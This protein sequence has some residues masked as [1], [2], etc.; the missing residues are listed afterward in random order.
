[1]SKLIDNRYRFIRHL[2]AG[3]MAQVLLVH[4][5]KL[6]RDVALKFFP[7][8]DPP[9]DKIR[10][11]KY[12]CESCQSFNHENLVKL[13]D[14][15]ML[16]EGHPYYTMEFLPFPSLEEVIKKK[17]RCSTEYTA[18]VIEQVLLAYK[19]F[20]PLGIVHRDIKPANLLIS[21]EG[22]VVVVDFG[23]AHDPNRTTLT[24]T[25]QFVGTPEYLAPEQL[26]D[27]EV[28]E[29]SDIYQLGLVAYKLLSGERA[30]EGDSLQEYL[31]NL[32]SGEYRPLKQFVPHISKDWEQYL[33]RC[34]APAM[35]DRFS[36]AD[37]ALAALHLLRQGNYGNKE[38][39]QTLATKVVTADSGPTTATV[40]TA[41]MS[42]Q[43]VL[44]TSVIF[45][46]LLFLWRFGTDPKKSKDTISAKMFRQP[47]MSGPKELS[48]KFEGPRK[49]VI[50]VTLLNDKDAGPI[51]VDLSRGKP[52]SRTIWSVPV[53]LKR[54]PLSPFSLQLKS[55][56][57]LQLVYKVNPLPIIDGLLKPLEK[58]A[59]K[60][61]GK[62]LTKC[63][64]ELLT[65][66]RR[67]SSE[68]EIAQEYEKWLLDELDKWGLTAANIESL[69]QNL[70]ILLH[71]DM[72]P[73]S[74]LAR[75][76]LPLQYL[77]AMVC[78]TKLPVRL[79]W[80]FLAQRLGFRAS[81]R[82]PM[83]KSQTSSVALNVDLRQFVEEKVR[84]VAPALWFAEN[85]T[86]QGF[87]AMGGISMVE[88]MLPQHLLVA[89]RASRTNF[90]HE[91]TLK[92]P[93]KISKK[94]PSWYLDL[95][96]WE[97]Q[98]NIGLI[99]QLNGRAS[100]RVLKSQLPVVDNE[101]KELDF[102]AHWI[103]IRLNHECLKKGK[104]VL[105]MR[106][107]T[108]PGQECK[109]ALGVERIRLRCQ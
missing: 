71:D 84:K 107:L 13:L 83:K 70:P 103:T 36:N 50:E 18:Q 102:Q 5:T 85:Q 46:L 94:T 95:L 11:F 51:K 14:Y 106:I 9:P 92:L 101:G 65:C 32:Q 99:L 96:A 67:K 40:N 2:G 81:R 52:L 97:W 75:R 90:K 1:M 66:L 93:K 41:K 3:G 58:L 22:R 31:H 63:Q 68:K 91:F 35:E 30:F 59:Q 79:P 69:K 4:D 104:N 42:R 82:D 6:D 53:P 43:I 77:E 19:Q 73:D 62:L 98:P 80:G 24:R 20:H 54:V 86:R 48:I 34:L 88:G 100:I 64:L 15:G 108:L 12:E 38:G 29:R 16:S 17:G 25:G 45:I 39:F 47:V 55:D 61:L 7:D 109:T 44:A 74:A 10:R 28:D 89:I 37:E 27:S 78:T 21:E 49:E 60:N 8:K 87:S 33:D 23:L 56:K 57:N 76:L 26:I 72:S 105:T